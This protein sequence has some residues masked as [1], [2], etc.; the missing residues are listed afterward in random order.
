TGLRHDHPHRD[1]HLRR[2]ESK[3]GRHHTK[4]AARFVTQANRLPDNALLSTKY[5]LPEAVGQHHN[6]TLRAIA[7]V[8]RSPHHSRNTEEREE[9]PRDGERKYVSR[10]AMPCQDSFG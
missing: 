8:E 2:K 1:G 7:L 5:R 10:W 3:I 9:I 4:D 6:A